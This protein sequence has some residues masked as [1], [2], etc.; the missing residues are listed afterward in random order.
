[1]PYV[2]VLFY[3]NAVRENR[4]DNP[5]KLAIFGTQDAD[6]EKQNTEN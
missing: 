2:N 5:E 3:L 6:E 1:M 4:M